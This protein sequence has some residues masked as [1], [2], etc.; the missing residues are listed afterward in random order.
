MLSN[1][2]RMKE[3]FYCKKLNCDCTGDADQKEDADRHCVEYELDAEFEK[4][5]KKKVGNRYERI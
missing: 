2:E 1:F 4:E 3:C 5:I